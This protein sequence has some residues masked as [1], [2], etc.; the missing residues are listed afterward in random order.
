MRITKIETALL[1]ANFEW[2]LVKVNTD[3]GVSG[4]AE[5]HWGYGVREAIHRFSH[6]LEGRDPR[7]VERLWYELYGVVSGAAWQGAAIA[8]INGLE[9]ALW[10]ALGKYIGQPVWQLLGGQYRD[11]VRILLDLHAGASYKPGDGTKVE[12]RNP[13]D[14]YTPRAYAQ[15]ARDAVARGFDSIKFDIDIPTIKELDPFNHCLTPAQV[16]RIVEIVATLRETVGRDVDIAIDCHWH[17]N[18]FDAIRIAKALEPF[19][20]LWLEDPVRPENVEAIAEVNRATSTPICTGENLYL[21]YGF[22]ELLERQACRIIEPD[23]PRSGGIGEMKRIAQLAE[24]HYVPL[25][26]HNVGGPL[27]TMAA[28]HVCVSVPNFLVLEFHADDVP[29]YDDLFVGDSAEIQN[30]RLAVTTSA[31][32]GVEID[33]D[34]AR[35]HQK[36]PDEPLWVSAR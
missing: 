12:L 32:F 21:S 1:Q 5:A 2:L 16:D 9:I 31:G 18:T 22:R 34:V 25:A 33:E 19:D 28:A 14:A 17:Y 23:F 6:H 27:A 3:E 10:D 35:E 29:W 13:E 7:N 15:Q 26:P 30:G 36:F 20:L 4:L 11:D 24:M 8:A